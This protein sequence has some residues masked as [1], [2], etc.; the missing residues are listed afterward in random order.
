MGRKDKLAAVLTD[1]SGTLHVGAKAIP[2]AVQALTNLRQH[3][4]K[5][6]FVTNTTK[7]TTANLVKTVQGC[8]F[9]IQEHEVFSSLR[10]A[11]HLLHQRHLRPLLLLHPD[12]LPEF[13][14][15]D[16]TPPNAVV[17]GLA[18]E[19]F[20]YSNLNA[21]FRLLM[22]EPDAPLIA[23]HKGR[24]HR[25][26]DGGLN[27]GPGPYVAALKYATGKQAQAALADLGVP[28]SA[29]VMVGDDVRDDVGGALQ[30]GLQAALL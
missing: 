29:A 2:G 7:D 16:C 27:L 4:L 21:A 13:A 6:R 10:A 14:D 24:Y 1:L 23:V 18:Q 28:A 30:A 17:V 9:D 22:A 3:G 26:P 12:A 11:K 8:G 25:A 19:A 15:V 5:V 20:S